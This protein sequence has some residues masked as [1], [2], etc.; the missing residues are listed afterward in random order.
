MQW[1]TVPL[2]GELVR[3]EDGKKSLPKFEEN[4]RAKYQTEFNKTATKLG[5]TITGEVSGIIAIDCDNTDTFKLFQ[6]LDPDYKFIFVSKGKLDK[7]GKEKD[8]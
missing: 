5:G 6:A 4:W 1:H 7:D 2:R 3:L 8:K